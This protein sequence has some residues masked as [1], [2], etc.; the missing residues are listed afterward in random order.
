MWEKSRGPAAGYLHEAITLAVLKTKMGRTDLQMALACLNIK[1]PSLQLIST[2]VN[3]QCDKMI[4]LNEAAI[5]D[6]KS[7]SCSNI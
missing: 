5:N 6:K 4:E 7:S 3:K 2:N 1:I